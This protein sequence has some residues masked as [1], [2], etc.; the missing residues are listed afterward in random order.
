MNGFLKDD[1]GNNSSIRGILL[2]S[3]I[4]LIYQLYE[5]RLAFRLEIQKEVVDYTGLSLL[6]TTM[7]INFI[8]VVI[9]KV[10]QK[11]YENKDISTDAGSDTL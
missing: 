9:L 5:Y 7:V 2:I 10:I 8:V 11:K 1:S 4:I 6:F 3:V